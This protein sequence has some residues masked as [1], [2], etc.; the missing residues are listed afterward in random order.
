MPRL[1]LQATSGS[2]WRSEWLPHTHARSSRE[3]S[4]IVTVQ[5][6][7]S[8]QA[9][10]FGYKQAA[11]LKLRKFP[12]K[13]GRV[14]AQQPGQFPQIVVSGGIGEVVPEQLLT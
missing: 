11:V 13:I 8:L 12:R 10:F 5:S 2:F 9:S 7:V 4:G 14:L 1:G 6:K 3:P